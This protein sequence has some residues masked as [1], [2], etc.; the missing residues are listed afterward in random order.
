MHSIKDKVPPT[1]SPE[2]CEM[3]WDAYGAPGFVALAYTLACRHGHAIRDRYGA[4]PFLVIAGGPGSGKTSLLR[5]LAAVAGKPDGF[6]EV[7]Q[8]T[9][10]AALNDM[11]MQPRATMPIVVSADSISRF[12]D[13]VKPCYDRNKIRDAVVGYR[14][15]PS[16]VYPVPAPGGVIV[17]SDLNDKIPYDFIARSAVIALRPTKTDASAVAVTALLR[18]TPWPHEVTDVDLLYAFRQ[19]HNGRT[20]SPKTFLRAFATAIDAHVP[21]AHATDFVEY[22]TNL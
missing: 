22:L 21:P 16:A 20:P 2:W 8:W 12:D 3:F 19:N 6:L 11:T 15:G 9:T 13:I 4:M 18:S 7:S 10:A 14:V 5:T 17:E 1:G